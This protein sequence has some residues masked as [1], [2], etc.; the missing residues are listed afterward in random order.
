[1]LI[2]F[3][4]REERKINGIVDLGIIEFIFLGS[5]PPLSMIHV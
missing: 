2:M 3:C 4:S 1:M 5:I